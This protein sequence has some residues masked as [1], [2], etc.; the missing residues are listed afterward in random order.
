MEMIKITVCI[1]DIP[2]E[3]IWTSAKTG[4]KYL[5][6]TIADRRT[7]DQYGNDMSV[8]MSQY[9]HEIENKSDKIYV[10]CGTK[11]IFDPKK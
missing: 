1:S 6:F 5:R 2:E 3:R 4:K 9:K 7:P 11:K 8:Y 10:G